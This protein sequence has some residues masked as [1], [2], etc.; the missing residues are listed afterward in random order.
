MTNPIQMAEDLRATFLKYVDTA[1]WLDHPGLMK[2]RRE[3][4]EKPGVLISDVLIEPV[5]PYPNTENFLDIC[6]EVGISRSIGEMVAKAIFPNVAPESLKLRQHQAESIRH[7]F[8]PGASEGRNVVVTSGTG[9]G[10]T[11]SFLL[12]LFLRL[13]NEANRWSDQAQAQWWWEGHEPKWTNMRHAEN[14]T[15]AVRSLVLYPT[16]ALVEDQM[17]RLRRAV[18]GLRSMQPGKPIWFG[19]YTGS[20]LGN[21]STKPST[22]ATKDAAAELGKIQALFENLKATN[23]QK[24]SSGSQDLIDLAQFTDAKSGEMLTRWDMIADPP[25]ILVTNYSMLNAIMMRHFEETIFSKTRKWL[26][27]DSQNVFTLVVDEL[28]LY[29]GTQG[30]EVAM[31]VRSLLNRLQLEPNSPQ[32]RIIATSASLTGDEASSSYLEQFFGVPGSSFSLQSGSPV[33]IDFKLQR[34]LNHSDFLVMSDSELTQA[35][36]RA[37]FDPFEE[38][39]RATPIAVLAERLTSSDNQSKSLLFEILEK[40]SS[41]QSSHSED[42]L[43]P[44]RAHMFVRTPR[45][46]WACTNSKCSGLAQSELDDASRNIGRLFATPL[47]NCPHCASRVL[48]L[49]YCFEC[50]DVSVG[51]YVLGEQGSDRLLAPTPVDER[52]AGKFVFHRLHDEFVWYRPGA[53]DNLGSKWT[54]G[55]IEFQFVAAHWN[56]ILG[57]LQVGAGLEPTGVVVQHA[58]SKITDKV[59]SLPTQCPRCH[60]KN[61][62]SEIDNFKSGQVRSP[63][64]AHTSGQPAAVELYLSQMIRSLAEGKTGHEGIQEAKTIV[65]TDSRDDAARTAAGVAKNHFRDLIRQVLRKEIQSG[66]DP[67]QLLS[68]LTLEEALAR[69]LGN[70]K[71]LQARQSSGEE[72]SDSDLQLLDEAYLRLGKVVDVSL[73]ALYEKISETLL[74]IGVNPGGT[75]PRD[76]FLEDWKDRS[77]AWYKAFEAP[78]KNLWAGPPVVQG[79]EKLMRKLRVAIA[80][81]LYDRAQRDIESVGI[82]YLSVKDQSAVSGPLGVDEQKELVNSVI[83]ILGL[84][85]RYSDSSSSEEASSMPKL[86]EKYLKNVSASKNIDLHSLTN[87]LNQILT[88]EPLMR[89]ISGWTL[90]TAK[91]DSSLQLSPSGD[92]WWRCESCNFSHLTPSLGVCVNAKCD[93]GKLQES[94]INRD[95]SDYYAWLAHQEPRRLR[96]NELTGQTKPLELQRDRQRLFKGAFAAGEYA[97]TDE[98]DVLSVTTTMEVGVDIGSLRATMMANVPPQRFNYQQRV[99]RA[100][101]AGQNLSFA[102]TICRDRSHDEYYFNRT[103]RITGDLPPQPFLDL[104]RRRIVQRVIVSEILRQA[105]LSLSNGPSWNGN[106]NHGTFG[107]VSEWSTFRQGVQ[108]FIS[109][110][111]LVRNIVDKLSAFTLINDDE[112][113]TIYQF[114]L[115]ELINEIDK[116]VSAEI[117]SSDTELSMHLAQYGLLPMFGFP[118]RVRN[119]WSTSVKTTSYLEKAIVSDR[120]LGMAVGSFAPGAQVVKDGFVY[121]VVG[122]VS[123]VPKGKQVDAVDPLGKVKRFCRCLSCGKSELNA[124]A[125][126]CSTCHGDYEIYNLFE[127]KGFRT[128]YQIHEY[129][130][131]NEQVSGAAAPELSLGAQSSGALSLETVDVEIFEQ[132]RL[133]TVNDN[134]GR[135]YKFVNQADGSVIAEAGDIAQ[136]SVNVIGEVRVTDA[137]LI[138]P[139]RLNIPTGAIGLYEQSSGRSAYVSLAEVLRRG[140]QVSLDLDPSELVAG[141]NPMR[142]PLPSEDP[143]TVKAQIAAGIYLSDTAENGAGYAVELGQQ[144]NF[145]KLIADTYSDAIERWTASRHAE[146]CDF[147]CPDCLRS[148]DNS[149]KHS[150]L[151]WR[152]ACDMLELISGH[153]LNLKRSQVRVDENLQRLVNTL[154]GA[155][156]TEVNGIP[157][158]KRSESKNAVLLGHPLWRTDKNWLN[159]AQA[160]AQAEIENDYESVIWQDAR[161]FRINPLSIWQHL[162]S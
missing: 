61:R 160:I 70:E 85:K 8:L 92:T 51:G 66:P 72:L 149:R 142:I 112:R 115:D 12:P 98:I 17:T 117:D 31:I 105:F 103:E 130:E 44:L 156:V 33:D 150:L 136:G 48:E 36:S 82:G 74:K 102:V 21:V 81:A 15:A 126:E 111:A 109:E 5:L 134:F 80:E 99:G 140:A 159:E 27:E 154:G 57:N 30:S 6:N 62:Q 50:G 75:D 56:P 88:T 52:Q 4:L 28:H 137:V 39:L 55:G 76:G 106:S 73:I 16:N 162:Q 41:P 38:R 161:M 32:L 125:T 138:T 151:D 54:V 37:C 148:Y 19:R 11:E 114:I 47:N 145:E 97:L 89:A 2:E 152:L 40:L 25:D 86:V 34:S 10:K 94:K 83:R 133:V 13:M 118:T 119:L 46:I 59:P 158:I 84:Q 131:D 139:N 91:V 23:E 101:R 108:K 90:L 71:I 7:S 120:P 129:T 60:F 123:Y 64:R 49:L 147:S 155:T 77:T 65:F 127:P 146:N 135:G 69:G 96:I 128:S 20:T 121:E 116:I 78:E 3:L 95:L 157:L 93:G 1:Y 144:S 22:A 29:R 153:S 110:T 53:L 26:E 43:I 35:I 104:K 100:G 122:F 63:V 143:A 79:R 113:K 107:L 67:K 18:R 141:I 58:K 9:S 45:G 24:L 124:T 14:R 132:S 87:Q 42:D 68:N